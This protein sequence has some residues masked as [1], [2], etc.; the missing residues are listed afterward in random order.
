MKGEIDMKKL[1]NFVNKK[2]HFIA[3][4][5]NYAR[6]KYCGLRDERWSK[7]VDRFIYHYQCGLEL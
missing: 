7:L 6:L 1:I 3:M 4:K 5:Y 2:Y